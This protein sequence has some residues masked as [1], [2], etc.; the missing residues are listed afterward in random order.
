MII[1]N[2]DPNYPNQTKNPLK[3]VLIEA[4]AGYDLGTKH[5]NKTPRD[6]FGLALLGS[7]RTHIRNASLLDDKQKE[8]V[9]RLFPIFTVKD[10][11]EYYKKSLF[12]FEDID[13]NPQDTQNTFAL[14]AILMGTDSTDIIGLM[15][16]YSFSD[17][18]Y[19]LQE[20]V[21]C[22]IV[23][24]RPDTLKEDEDASQSESV[25]KVLA[26]EEINNEVKTL[27]RY[28]LEADGIT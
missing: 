14:Q 6:A 25:K 16:P 26:S 2:P 23:I 20:L 22:L 18:G 4:L 11:S 8:S 27:I 19:S 13:N 24:E 21:Y 12:L 15:S 7:Y 3:Y 28:S 1:N 17:D 5:L 10:L 9:K